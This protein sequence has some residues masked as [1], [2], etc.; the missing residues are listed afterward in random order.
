M[1]VSPTVVFASPHESDKGQA[2]FLGWIENLIIIINNDNISAYVSISMGS[3][4]IQR[5]WL[6]DWK[7]ERVLYC[8]R[9]RNFSLLDMY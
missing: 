9:G 7:V 2:D 1:R 6:Y 5:C 3:I 4:S 8:R